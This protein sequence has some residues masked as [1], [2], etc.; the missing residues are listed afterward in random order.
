MRSATA[1]RWD[2]RA[3]RTR[4]SPFRASL[5]FFATIGFFMLTVYLWGKV[6]IDFAVRENAR[7]A[8]ECQ[9]LRRSINDL[10]VE[11]HNLKSYSRITTL[12]RRQG[13]A[14]VQPHQRQDL[15]VDFSGLKKMPAPRRQ[16]AV[17]AGIGA[18]AVVSSRVIPW[19]AE[20]RRGSR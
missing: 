7:I 11:I 12:A 13:L 15:P 14:F 16:E 6:R 9:D 10:R 3:S 17:L 20:D 2:P 4:E 1:N 19:L 18:P 5:L 8:R